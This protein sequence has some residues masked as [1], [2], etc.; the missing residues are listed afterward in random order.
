MTKETSSPSQLVNTTAETDK[1]FDSCAAGPLLVRREGKFDVIV[2]T[3]DYYADLIDQV[4]TVEVIDDVGADP[5]LS[6]LAAE[7]G[8][9][10]DPKE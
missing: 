4:Q 10:A 2:M 6:D 5:L 8:P 9:R 1:L 3:T 7:F